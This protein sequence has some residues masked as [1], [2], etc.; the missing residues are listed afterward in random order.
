VQIEFLLLLRQVQRNLGK[1]AILVTHDMGVA[2]K[3][4]DR[5]AVV[6]AARFVATGSAEDVLLRPAH[7]YSAGLLRST[8]HAGM[9]GVA[10]ETIQGSRRIL[11]GGRRAAH[12]HRAA[13]M[14]SV[15]I[16]PARRVT[17]RLGPAMPRPA[18]GSAR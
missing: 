4:F 15:R 7:P 18:A 14:P 12:S 1:A 6:Y 16:W 3:I 8:V 5:V 10:L 13:A 11:A 2:A 17:W 9:R